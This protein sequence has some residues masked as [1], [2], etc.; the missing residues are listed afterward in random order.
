[1]SYL[2]KVMK[3]QCQHLTKT[4]QNELLKWL[5]FFKYLF[6]ETL[7]KW[8]TDPVELMLKDDAKLICSWPYIVPKLH[9][10]ILKKR[11]NLYVY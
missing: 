3:N 5:Q 10:E 9:V 7:G 11:L 2:N 1:M 8:K 4:Q 6:D